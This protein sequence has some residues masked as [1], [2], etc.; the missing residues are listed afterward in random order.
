MGHVHL[1]V[2]PGTR[3]WREVVDLVEGGA[4]DDLVIAS[5]A[6]AAE[7]DLSRAVDDR[8]FIESLRLLAALPDAARVDDLASGL[9]DIGIEVSGSPD[10]MD[11]V[12]GL[13]ERL[14]RVSPA[15]SGTDFTELARRALLTTVTREV[16]SVLPGLLEPTTGDLQGALRRLGSSRVFAALARA[17]FT[18]LLSGTLRYWL[19]RTLSAQIGPGRRFTDLVD[20]RAFDAAL[21]QYC[22]EGTRI[23]REFAAGWYGKSQREGTRIGTTEATRFGSVAFKKII[24][25]LGRKRD[26]HG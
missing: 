26:E 17:Y 3:K 16:G 19:D 9:R 5:A 10:L 15:G 12:V 13:G 21:D 23:V 20:R 6:I 7:R 14:D 2:L 11:L 8:V 1:G 18:S 24:E 4:S 22:L 25:E